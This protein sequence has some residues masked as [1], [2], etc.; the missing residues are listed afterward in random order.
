MK[1]VSDMGKSIWKDEY[2]I[3]AYEL[4][5]SGASEHKMAKILGISFQT[6]TMWEKKKPI[7]KMAVKQGRR[8]YAGRPGKVPSFRDFVF[9]RMDPRL[10]KVWRALNE[11]EKKKKGLKSINELFKGQGKKVRQHM[12]IYAWCSSNFSKSVAMRKVGLNK[13]TLTLWCKDP[14]FKA[15]VEEIDWHKKNFFE[16]HLIKLV[17]GGDTSATIFANKT[18]NKDRYP[19]KQVIDVNMDAQIDSNI[20]YLDELKCMPLADRK[21]ILK[22]VRKERKRK[23]KQS[24]KM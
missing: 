14:D 20:V 3:Q 8:E 18:F 1:G 22:S 11:I 10:K 17:K 23:G 7:F 19:D 6:F 5:K 13:H 15:L 21:R 2:I 4:A 24:K 16:D 9:K 12:F